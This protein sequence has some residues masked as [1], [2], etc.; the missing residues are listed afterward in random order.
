MTAKVALILQEDEEEDAAWYTAKSLGRPPVPSFSFSE[1]S[2]C[3]R[4]T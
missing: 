3:F 2:S 4:K 1:V